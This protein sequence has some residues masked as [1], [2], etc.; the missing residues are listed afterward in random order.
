VSPDPLVPE[1]VNWTQ[2]DPARSPG[3]YESFYLRG[4]HPG[5]PLAF[6]LRY[7]IFSPVAA[8]EAACGQLWAVVFDGEL[9]THT[10]AKVD[11]PL[12]DCSFSTT[13]LDVRIGDAVLDGAGLCGRVGEISWNLRY[14]GAAAPLYLLPK[15][16]YRGDFPKAKTL[17]PVPL[18]RFTGSL[19]AADRRVEVDG[20]LGSQNHNWGSRHTDRYTFGQVA[21]FDNAPESTL[22]VA[23]ARTRIGP[24]WTPNLT[25]LVL[26]HDGRE[27]AIT[28]LGRAAR[29]AASAGEGWWRFA[30]G[31]RSTRVEGLIEAPRSA[32]VVFEYPD[33]PGGVK[34]CLNTKLARCEIVVT[35]PRTGRR[36]VLTSSH[37]ALFEV[38]GDDPP[39]VTS[40]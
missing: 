17:V 3:H 32:F 38:L 39:A 40:G 22:E 34:Y 31:D 6:W 26:R 7:T 8:P 2:Y 36:E 24:L 18:A 23:T 13:S 14:A 12:S 4:N 5:R 25:F 33:P 35:H 11:V 28:S 20:W 29:A 9:G 1:Q 30:T 15:G 21:G 37:N 27:H 10:S 19:D 16:L